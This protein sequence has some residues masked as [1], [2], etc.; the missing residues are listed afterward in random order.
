MTRWLVF[1]CATLPSLAFAQEGSTELSLEDV[2]RSTEAHHPRVAAAMANEAMARSELQ[3]ARGGFD[4]VIDITAKL[5]TGGYYE[6]RRLDV[7]ITQPTPLWGAEVY[8]GYRV[9]LDVGE[10][11]YPDYYSDQTRGG[12]ELRVGLRVPLWR[13]GP[14]DARRAARTRAEIGIDAAEQN[15]QWTAI[16]LRQSA[17]DAYFAWVAAGRR[18]SVADQLLALA[19]TRQRW[20]DARVA[21]GAIA[22]IESLEA[23]RSVL[24]RRAKRISAQRSVERTALV[25][26]LFLRT[27]S[28]QPRL[29]DNSTLPQVLPLPP[30]EPP[31]AVTQDADTARAA[32]A[33]NPLLRQ[34]IASLQSARLSRDLAQ[35]QRAPRVDAFFGASRDFGEGSETLGGNV[36]EAG[37]VFSMP[38]A[39]RT[40]RGRLGAAEAN[41]RILTEEV[42]F[43]EDQLL[44]RIADAES[45]RRNAVEQYAIVAE[46]LEAVERLAQAERMRF[47]A[48]STSLFVVNQ[49][50][51]SL[52]EAAV[53]EVDA[54]REQW[55][56]RARVTALASCVAP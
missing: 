50:E 43:L 41:V 24:S 25:L 54:A 10:N 15:L 17:T 23:R 37:L 31:L 56:A 6:L 26:S 38:L 4:P 1:L 33:C 45:A 2:W 49:R 21:A 35:A 27:S 8:A 39:M 51:Q 14:L 5:R 48:G 16:T 55:V 22:E 46:L 18:A 44:A 13:D 11:S 20:V 28:G 9:G 36:L 29:A 7:E 3:A 30:A 40:A 53:A 47:E 32:L 42:R 19:E 34:K 52:A 12:G